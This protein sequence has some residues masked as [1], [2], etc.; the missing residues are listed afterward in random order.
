MRAMHT[1]REEASHGRVSRFS[2]ARRLPWW[3]HNWTTELYFK[4]WQLC[5]VLLANFHTVFVGRNLVDLALASITTLSGTCKPLAVHRDNRYL[6]IPPSYEI[7]PLICVLIGLCGAVE[8]SVSSNANRAEQCIIE[9][10]WP[11]NCSIQCL[12]AQALQWLR[13]T[14]LCSVHC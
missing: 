10:K 2:H 14:L 1:C 7:M 3:D 5:S 13:P 11:N 8:R 9:P 12:L 6:F 4:N